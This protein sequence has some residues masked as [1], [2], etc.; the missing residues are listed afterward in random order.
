MTKPSE[1]LEGTTIGTGWRV[2]SRIARY[3]GQTGSTFS[4]GYIVE[5]DGKSAFMKAMD[6]VEAAF[7]ADVTK[8][9]QQISSIILFE[10][11]LLAICTRENL[12]KIVQLL[13]HGQYYPSGQ[14]GNLMAASEFFIFELA[15]ADIRKTVTFNGLSD[16]AWNLRVLHQIAVGLDQ[17][18]RH[19]LSHQ[20][21]KPSNV[22]VM[23]HPV[24]KGRDAP[25]KLG[26]LGRAA[27]R[28]K[29]GPFDNMAIAGDRNYAPLEAHYG[30]S[31]PEW[32]DRRDAC[33]C[34]LLGSMLSFLFTG[35]GM[36]QLYLMNLAPAHLP[37]GWRGTFRDV[38]PMLLDAHAK[39]LDAVAPHVLE[40]VR[41]EVIAILRE[42]THP[43]PEKRG[44]PKAR[45]QVGRPVGMERYVSR[46]SGLVSRA[47]IAIRMA[48]P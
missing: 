37:G 35:I 43:D 14:Q 10:R 26:D 31:T 21:L 11:D 27:S 47:E 42:L 9:L 24:A 17:L 6:Y 45:A 12:T 2:V 41:G 22:L 25:I 19:E 7:A 16:T 30:F 38:L 3:P 33:D 46:I 15:Q 44:D 23:E 40:D 8:K 29:S 48:K 13:E 34:F 36:T 32:V 39:T 4:V 1:Q 20:D 18:H 5:K 28:S